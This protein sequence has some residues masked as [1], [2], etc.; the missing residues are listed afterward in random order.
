MKKEILALLP[1]KE[2][3]RLTQE[4]E[5]HFSII[6]ERYEKP[7]Q[8][9]C[10]KNTRDYYRA[11]D[12]VQDVFL[13]VLLLIREGKY[14]E[15]ELFRAWLFRITH[16]KCYDYHRQKTRYPLVYYSPSGC[17]ADDSPFFG[18][19][20]SS[21]EIE[22]QQAIKRV[23]AIL[24]ALPAEQREVMILRYYAELTFK[25]I[26]EMTSKNIMTTL[27]FCQRAKKSIRTELSL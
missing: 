4:D 21:L 13:K 11:G 18:I 8:S 6:V 2:I 25:E 15:R 20:D 9:L 22:Q 7:L 1:D 5:A 14:S 10:Y 24:E 3:I 19:S 26:A 16:N 27:S 23:R 17:S 12:I